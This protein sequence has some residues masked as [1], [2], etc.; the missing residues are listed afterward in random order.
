MTR[1][2]RGTKTLLIGP[3]GVGKTT[4]LLTFIEAGLDLYVIGTDPGFEESLLDEM[5]KKGLPISK[6]HY[7]YVPPIVQGFSALKGVLE[8]ANTMG[9]GDL[10]GLKNG[11]NKHEY[12]QFFAILEA[13]SN[14]TCDRTGESF[15]AVDEWPEDR[16]LAL[17]SLTGLNQ[18]AMQNHVGG[19][20]CLHEGEWQVVQ[21]TEENFIRTLCSNLKCFFVLT[22]HVTKSYNQITGLPMISID[23]TGAKL[24]PKLPHMFSDVVVAVKEGSKFRWSTSELNYDL[25]NRAL[26]ISDALQ[27]TFQQIVDVWHE[28][29]VTASADETA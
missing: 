16:A 22:A 15:G 7:M 25:K 19:K 1:L 27:P 28:R 13:C 9:F 11:I 3:P 8:R 6:L 24:G 20:P 4:A 17:D 29:N 5:R 21:N 14:F 18:I 26:P 2:T 12:K 23:A 10:G